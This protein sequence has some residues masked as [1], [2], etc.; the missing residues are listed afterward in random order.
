MFEVRISTK[1][2][3]GFAGDADEVIVMFQAYSG[4]TWSSEMEFEKVKEFLTSKLD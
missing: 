1:K 3:G 2:Y 4:T